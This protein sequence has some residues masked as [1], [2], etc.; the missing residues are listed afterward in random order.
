MLSKTFFFSGDKGF[1]T[2]H[3]ESPQGNA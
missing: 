2:A 3:V 1:E